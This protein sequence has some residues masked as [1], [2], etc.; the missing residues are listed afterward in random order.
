M[1]LRNRELK[2]PKR[3]LSTFISKIIVLCHF[4][5]SKVRRR[6]WTYIRLRCLYAT[7]N[8]NNNCNITWLYEK[9][10]WIKSF[11]Y[12]VHRL[13]HK[14][15]H[16]TPQQ[17]VQSS[18]PTKLFFYFYKNKINLKKNKHASKNLDCRSIIGCVIFFFI[19]N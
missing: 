16:I 1:S 9:S 10:K 5:Y 12:T 17:H 4:Q 18:H 2:R 8:Y 6:R 11:Y 19:N 7:Y 15:S 3:N 14:Y 13:Y